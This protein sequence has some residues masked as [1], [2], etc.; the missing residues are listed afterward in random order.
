MELTGRVVKK[1][2]AA[3]SKSERDA[4]MFETGS[5]DMVLR[6]GG[7]N[8]FRDP[9]LNALVGKTIRA[10]GE[11]HGYTFLMSQW[12]EIDDPNPGERRT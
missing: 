2:V 6:R 4:V 1:S 7:G 11:L 3:G 8:P 9:F 10:T 12:Q 5:G